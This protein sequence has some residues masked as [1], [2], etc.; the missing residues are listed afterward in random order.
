MPPLPRDSR[1]KNERREGAKKFHGAVQKMT[2]SRG[3]QQALEDFEE[4]PE[5]A[6][7]DPKGFLQS[8]GVDVPE[9]ATIEILER[10][11]SYC[12]C[13][14]VCVLWWC[15]DVCVCVS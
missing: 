14:R 10:E 5:E 6:K 2:N 12:W 4:N 1:D 9:D 11:G 15:W 8:R 7:A 13:W 3:F